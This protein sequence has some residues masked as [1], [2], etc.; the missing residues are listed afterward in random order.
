MNEDLT[1]PLE[2]YLRD[3]MLTHK[4]TADQKAFL[5]DKLFYLIRYLEGEK[6][7]EGDEG[8]VDDATISKITGV[9]LEMKSENVIKLLVGA[10]PLKEKIREVKNLIG[11][12]VD[13]GDQ[14]FELVSKMEPSRAEKITGMLLEMQPDDIRAAITSR[15]VLQQSVNKAVQILE[16]MK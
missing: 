5:G 6:E 13:V 8:R 11:G 1:F 14:L 10:E 15:A 4:E 2:Q 7:D 12:S 16:Q 9:L 3:G